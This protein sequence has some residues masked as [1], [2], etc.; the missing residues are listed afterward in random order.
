MARAWQ[1][2]YANPGCTLAETAGELVIK[3]PTNAAG[4]CAYYSASSYDM[5]NGA[6]TVEAPL[7]VNTNSTAEVYFSAHAEGEG[8]IEIAQTNGAI[9]FRKNTNGM[10]ELLGAAVYS[11]LVHRWWRMREQGGTTYWEYSA[12]GVAWMIGA[13][14][15]PNPMSMTAI[16]VSMGGGAYE[17]VQSPGEVHFDNLNLPP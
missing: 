15:S 14:E 6:V 13:M 10:T 7:M 1:R 4:Y 3:P 11:P 5:T 12:D 17:A 8:F 2:S 16:D 9:E